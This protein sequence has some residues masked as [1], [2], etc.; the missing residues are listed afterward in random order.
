MINLEEVIEQIERKV[1]VVVE[2][3]D[4]ARQQNDSLLK[5]KEDLLKELQ[6]YKTGK[7]PEEILVD[8]ASGR[9]IREEDERV[10]F[11]EEIDRY[12]KD[13]DHCLDLIK[14]L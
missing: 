6:A 4:E 3:L 1:K 13:I 2:K 14:Q 11:K 7:N 12:I 10:A 8:D 9:S 5:D